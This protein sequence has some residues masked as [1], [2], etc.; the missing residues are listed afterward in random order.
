MKDL[1]LGLRALEGISVFS[2]FELRGRFSPLR[3]LGIRTSIFWHE[4][5][6]KCRRS[7]WKWWFFFEYGIVRFFSVFFDWVS[8]RFRNF[9]AMNVPGDGGVGA[10]PVFGSVGAGTI[11]DTRVEVEGNPKGIFIGANVRIG[12]G[13]RLICSG[14][15]AKIE[16]GSHTVLMSGAIL[17]T[18][19]NGSIR[20]GEYNS[21]NPY[22]VIYGHGSLSCGDYVRIAAHT[23]IIPANHVFSGLDRPIARQGLSKKGIRIGGDVWIGAGCRL[24]DGIVIGDG[25]VLAAGAVVNRDVPAFAVVGGVPAKILKMRNSGGSHANG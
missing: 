10:A 14:V 2:S 18:G 21:V 24:L 16:I 11:V 13:V 9:P 7:H 6:Q 8:R 4:D 1:V 25:A 23:V 3:R 20:L 15:D 22:C 17:D 19:P 12:S 5:G